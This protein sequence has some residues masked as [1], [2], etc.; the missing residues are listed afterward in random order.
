MYLLDWYENDA[1]AR[2][3]SLA[4]SV[5]DKEGHYLEIGPWEGRTSVSIC[6]SI[7]PQ[8]LLCVD[9]WNGFTFESSTVGYEHKTVT[10]AKSTNVKELFLKNMSIHVLDNYRVMETDAIELSQILKTP[11]KF[12]HINA[13]NNYE[14]VNACIKSYLPNLIKGGIICGYH[15]M[16]AGLHRNDLGGGVQKAVDENIPNRLFKG[17]LWWWQKN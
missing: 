12:L 17:D 10:T 13:D 14:F 4:E 11:L 6:S 9:K 1:C 5:I 16:T 8:V 15:Y 2:L 3:T 7:A